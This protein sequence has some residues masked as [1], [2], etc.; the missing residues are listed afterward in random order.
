LRWYNN[1]SASH[2][3]I[4]KNGYIGILRIKI[5]FCVQVMIHMGSIL[6][7]AL[8]PSCIACYT[9]SSSS[10]RIRREGM[11]F[12]YISQGSLNLHQMNGCN[13]MQ[14]PI[15]PRSVFM[16]Q[17]YSFIDD[18][19]PRFPLTPPPIPSACA[20]TKFLKFLRSVSVYRIVYGVLQQD[21]VYS[22]VNKK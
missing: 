16:H 9:I 15:Y 17:F 22:S 13:I 2:V 3:K 7:I 8:L 5:T 1:A 11:K 14:A 19:L 6:L 4:D 12:P 10:S 21:L 20:C 18:F